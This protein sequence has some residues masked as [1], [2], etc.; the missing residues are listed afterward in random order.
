[1]SNISKKICIIGPNRDND[2]WNIPLSFFNEFKRLGHEVKIFN[3]L[4]DD[5]PGINQFN[6]KAWT[7]AGLHQML[8]DANNGIFEPDIIIHFDFGLF[9]S[10][11]LNKNNFPSAIW[12]Y[13]SGDDPQCFD[14]NFDKV[15]SGNYD[16]VLSPDIK[17]VFKYNQKGYNAIW[18][19]HFADTLFLGDEIEPTVPCITSRH[20]S[21]PFFIE[22][23]NKLGDKF[24]ARDEFIPEDKHLQF[25][26]TGKIIIQNSKYKE[27][28]R[29][30]FEG[31]LC[32]RLVITD[33]ISEDTGIDKI[34]KEGEDIV[35]FDNIDDCS[36]KINYYLENEKERLRISNNGYNKIKSNHTVSKRVENLLKLIN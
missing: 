9:R 23:K 20:Y 21:E 30:I 2:K 12:V 31:M 17:S 5:Q 33:R 6:P 34:F 27:I 1:M 22:L 24:E 11:L 15:Q 14:Y 13:E 4:N 32:N 7:E 19:P 10:P 3:N 26:K 28:T 25:L 18:S 8:Q 16:Y 35:Y 36:E 29:R